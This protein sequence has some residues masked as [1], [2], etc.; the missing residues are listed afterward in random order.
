MNAS[1]IS[2]IFLFSISTIYLLILPSLLWGKDISLKTF[3][4][5]ALKNNLELKAFQREINSFE[6]EREAVKG[7]YFPRL[8]LEE[9]FYKSDIPAQVFTFKLN[10]ELF[11]SK[12]FEI[13]RLNNPQSRANFETRL[14]LELPVWLGGKI[15]AQEKMVS[16]Q[17]T[18]L[19]HFYIRKEELVLSQVYQAY[20]WAILSKESIKVAESSIKEAQEYL[21][22]AKVRFE[23]GTA[24]SSDIYR[25]EV[26][27]ALAKESLEK[28]KNYYTLA[29][30]NLGLLVNTNL[31]DFEVEDLA[32][33]PQIEISQ[34]KKEAL[35]KR[36]DLQA[37][38]EEIK[39][40]KASSRVIL[41]ENLPQVSAFASYSL[42]DRDI[43]FGSSGSGYMVGIGLSWAFDTGL[44][45]YKRAQAELQ[46]AASL[47]EKYRYLKETIFYEI[48]KAY[49][50]YQIALAK[51]KSADERIKYSEEMVRIL[52]L[53]YQNGLAR[54]LDLLD[55]QTQLD[56][57][58][59]ERIQALKDLHQ[60]YLEIL[61]AGGKLKD[62]L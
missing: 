46:R 23:A 29:K 53:R 48:D 16:S 50:D 4:E 49:G 42:N 41:S 30:K 8:K 61:L 52:S 43:P 15:Q 40:R 34:I 1:F 7:S 54:M 58:R 36:K 31:E 27:L 13:K 25:A 22:M 14:T 18:S 60:A 2:R 32:L 12:D 20:L 45:T 6:L 21:R 11:T 9:F 39:A 51:L 37:L 3:L 19:Q 33:P 56:L 10:Q 26:Y 24:L 44:T 62:S 59:F 35:F 38:E 17:L 57:A 28:A 55:A 47:E 5:L